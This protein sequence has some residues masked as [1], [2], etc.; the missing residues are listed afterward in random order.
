MLRMLATLAATVLI[1]AGC[2]G[3]PAQPL[4]DQN[5]QTVP[6]SGVLPEGFVVVARPRGPDFTI[7]DITKGGTDYVGV[8][9]GNYASFPLS[10]DSQGKTSG[11]NPQVFSVSRDGEL[12]PMEYLWIDEDSYGQV[13]VWVQSSLVG[14][15]EATAREIAQ[16]IR[17]AGR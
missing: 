7:Y 3:T 6:F 12:R 1:L 13:H 15:E 2:A 4:S 17:P 16:S 9:V 8:Y 14:T 11:A 5:S 10:E